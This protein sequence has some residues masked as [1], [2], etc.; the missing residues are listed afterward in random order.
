MNKLIKILQESSEF[1]LPID[2]VSTR[3]LN[4]LEN[5]VQ[6]DKMVQGYEQFAKEIIIEIFNLCDTDLIKSFLKNLF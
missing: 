3:I 4:L 5:N 6:L 2:T 1:S